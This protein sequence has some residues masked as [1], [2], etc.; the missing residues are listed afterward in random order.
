[1]ARY[2]QH[3]ITLKLIPADEYERPK[4]RG[5]F[6]QG[7][8]QSFVSPIDGSVISDRKKLREHNEKHRVVNAAE[9]SPEY[10]ERVR[11]ERIAKQNSPEERLK[12]KRQI[13]ESWIQA[14]RG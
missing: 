8:V 2:I 7:D 4:E 12:T 11:K 6:V 10:C 1:M 14:E 13:Y 5:H 3:P 9:F